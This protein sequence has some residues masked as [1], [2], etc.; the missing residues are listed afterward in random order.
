M[1]FRILDSLCKMAKIRQQASIRN[2]ILQLLILHGV[3]V[4]SAVSAQTLGQALDLP[5]EDIIAPRVEHQV[6]DRGVNPNGTYFFNTSVTDNVGVQ[7]VSLFYRTIGEKQYV[8]LPMSHQGGDHYAALLSP[9]AVKPPGIEYYIQ[10][11]DTSGNAVLVGAAFSPLQLSVSEAP[12]SSPSPA[13]LATGGAAVAHEPNDKPSQ[14]S[15]SKKWWWIAAG[16][17]AVGAIAAGSS[18][19]GGGSSHDNTPAATTGTLTVT[20]PLP[21]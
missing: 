15:T 19:G 21:Q 2:G 6:A 4:A 12:A 14:K 1:S 20:A 18:G 13:Q 10:A 3:I 8:A 16:V 11:K 9:E 7:S 17:I 5:S